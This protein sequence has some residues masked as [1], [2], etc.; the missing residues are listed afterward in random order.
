VKPDG[1]APAARGCRA[2]IG[3]GANLGDPTRAL[4]DALVRI[5]GLPGTRLMAVS[6]RYR[7]APVG[8]GGP[9]Y[10][11]QVAEIGTSMEPATLLA[12]LHA[13]EQRAGRQRGPE[14]NAPRTLD[15]DLLLYGGP[16]DGDGEPGHTGGGAARVQDSNGLTLPHPRM[17]LR[18]FV[19]MPLAEINPAIDIPG[20]G[21]AGAVLARLLT[22]SEGADQRCERVI[23]PAD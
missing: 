21:P 11:N 9:D 20:H 8:G 12:A 4:A 16:G 2:F 5:G 23:D 17:H 18:C 7:S 6:S 15:L 10:F 19:M 13:I 1:T 3:L 14:R 22:R